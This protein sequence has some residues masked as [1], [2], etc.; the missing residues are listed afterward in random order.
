MQLFSNNARAVLAQVL[1]TQDPVQWWKPQTRITVVADGGSDTFALQVD[2]PGA[3]EPSSDYQYATLSHESVPGVYEVVKLI[4]RLSANEYEV[5]RGEDGTEVLEWPIGTAMEGRVTA[6]MLGGLVQENYDR[7]V[8]HRDQ[9]G[10]MEVPSGRSFLAGCLVHPGSPENMVQI[11]GWPVMQEARR[12]NLKFNLQDA[13]QI[14]P[15]VMGRTML[16]SLGRVDAWTSG[17]YDEG[18]I[19]RPAVDD[20]YQY[21]LA[22]ENPFA[23]GGSRAGGDIL[24]EPDF[25]N[26][27]ES[28]GYILV[29][30]S[31]FGTP[32][33]D[34]RLI[35]VSLP[36][37]E[38]FQAVGNTYAYYSGCGQYLMP[39]EIGFVCT[40]FDGT[41]APN[42]SIGTPEDHTC[43]VNNQS[44]EQISGVRQ[45]QRWPITAGGALVQHLHF[46]TETPAAGVFEGFFF[47]RGVIMNLLPD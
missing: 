30:M 8:V 11:S 10:V 21:V 41:A 27:L 47:W 34:G 4:Q 33:G 26:G 3:S 14:T 36:L 18:A 28:G 16:V 24:Q 32:M 35:Q 38:D 45:C 44:M 12:D 7:P 20:G 13:N 37:D 29:P 9:Q 23:S 46:K 40:K 19:L 43:F 39:T 6:G 5:M 25:V 42:V 17:R 31:L 1:L 22:C 2:D 15:E